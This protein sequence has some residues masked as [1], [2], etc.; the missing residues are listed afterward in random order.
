M[1][2]NQ[3]NTS[4]VNAYLGNSGSCTQ[5]SDIIGQIENDG[6]LS[7]DNYFTMPKDDAFQYADLSYQEP[8]T[9][10]QPSMW[11]KLLSILGLGNINW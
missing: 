3:F 1:T 10:Q 9:Q 5:I 11:E 8:V 4:M 7:E 2:T 6:Y